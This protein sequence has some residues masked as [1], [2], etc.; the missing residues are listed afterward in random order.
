MIWYKHANTWTF[1]DT[2]NAR[3]HKESNLDVQTYCKP[4]EIFLIH[5]FSLVS[6][7]RHHKRFYQWRSFWEQI[8]RKI[9]KTSRNAFWIE[10][11]QLVLKR[12]TSLKSNSVTEKRQLNKRAV[13]HVWRILP[14]VTQYN[15][16]LPNFETL[17]TRKWHLI[18]NQPQLREIFTEPPLKHIPK[19][20]PWK[21]FWWEQSY[22]GITQS[23][24]EPQESLRPVNAFHTCTVL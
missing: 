12:N 24:S 3:S 2:K 15:P 8:P 21:T 1:L 19:E 14:F 18:Q 7:T 22:K 16:A 20:N 5:E 10:D 6:P 9:W 17:L 11:T 13:M 4:T 23:I